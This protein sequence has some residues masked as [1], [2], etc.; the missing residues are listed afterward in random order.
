MGNSNGVLAKALYYR[1]EAGVTGWKKRES[2]PYFMMERG[3]LGSVAGCQDRSPARSG[4][5]SRV[6]RVP[7]YEMGPDAVQRHTHT[8]GSACLFLCLDNI[9]ESSAHGK[10]DATPAPL[11]VGK[12][13][14]H[15]PS[16]AVSQSYI[17]CPSDFELRCLLV[18]VQKWEG[19]ENVAP[20]RDCIVVWRVRL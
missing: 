4:S 2:S 8:T 15:P 17:T 7:S 5:Q 10:S 18:S 20:F 9:Q 11:L 16:C 1:H 14:P 6:V 3:G 12:T 13:C 19:E